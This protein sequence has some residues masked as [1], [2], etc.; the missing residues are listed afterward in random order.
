MD[1]KRTERKKN[2]ILSYGM[3]VLPTTL[4]HFSLDVNMCT[5]IDQYITN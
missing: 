4:F 5:N 2:L 1:T 3:V